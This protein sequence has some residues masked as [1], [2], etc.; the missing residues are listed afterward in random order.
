M[1]MPLTELAAAIGKA[2]ISGIFREIQIRKFG[3]LRKSVNL[4]SASCDG[5]TFVTC[6]YCVVA[7]EA[8]SFSKARVISNNPGKLRALEEAGL[9][10][11]ERVSIE[12][13]PSEPG[14]KYLQ[15]KKEKLGHL[16]GN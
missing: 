11:V 10:V 4:I 5:D 14:A 16:L 3:F 9:E 6:R 2:L 8:K 12:V 7:A 1:T 15:T 13:E